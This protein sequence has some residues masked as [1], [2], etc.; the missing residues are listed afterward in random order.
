MKRS[1]TTLQSIFAFNIVLI[2]MSWSMGWAATNN[3]LTWMILLLDKEAEKIG[4]VTS[5]GRI[6]LDRNLG[7]FRV[8]RSSTDIGA[9]GDLYQ[10][11]RLADGHQKRTSLTTTTL[12][13]SDRPGHGRFITVSSGLLDWRTPQNDFLW[14]GVSGTN[15]PCPDGFRLPTRTELETERMSWGTNDSAGAFASPLKLVVAGYR[16]NDDGRLYSSD[17]HGIYS[18]STVSGSEADFLHIFPYNPTNPNNNYSY[19]SDSSRAEGFS[20]RCIMDEATVL[21]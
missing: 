10:W 16:G 14:Q 7:A 1:Y 3:K 17:T 13:N 8:A 6:W 12:S 11:G 20:V 15:N 19:V 9:Y 4:T 21:P 2:F 18:S 5:V